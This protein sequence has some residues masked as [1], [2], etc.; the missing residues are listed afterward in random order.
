[1]N[2]DEIP[3]IETENGNYLSPITKIYKIIIDEEEDGSEGPPS[4][5]YSGFKALQQL[6]AMND[7][8]KQKITT[9]IGSEV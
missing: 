2:E 4:S 9:Y 3:V 1:M 8:E 5:F 7:Y 6:Y